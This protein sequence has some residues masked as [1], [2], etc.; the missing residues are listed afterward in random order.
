MERL[1]LDLRG[2]RLHVLGEFGVEGFE[3]CLDRGGRSGTFVFLGVLFEG[4]ES[5]VCV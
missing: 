5:S 3:F 2:E 1:V 4:I